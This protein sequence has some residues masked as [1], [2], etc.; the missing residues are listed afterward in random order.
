MDAEGTIASQARAH[1]AAVLLDTEA[2]RKQRDHNNNINTSETLATTSSSAS[3]TGNKVE[4]RDAHGIG[5]P[6]GGHEKTEPSK[7]DSAVKETDLSRQEGD[8]AVH[9]FYAKAAGLR[10]VVFFLFA[11]AVS[12]ATDALSQIWVVWWTEAIAEDPD[13]SNGKWLGV[14]A[15]LGIIGVLANFLA[16]WEIF[17]TVI[18]K[19]GL[20]FHSLLVKTVSQAPMSFFYTVDQGVTV[21]RF[22]QD[23]QLIDMELPG[24]ALGAAMALATVVG[25]AVIIGVTGRYIAI[26]FPF[27]IAVFYIIQKFYL[28]TSRQMR[29]LDIEHTAPLYSHTIEILDGLASIRA[30]SYEEGCLKAMCHSLNES[31]RPAYILACLQQWLLFASDMTVA[32]MAVLLIIIT[33]TLRQEI[34]VGFMGLALSNIVAFGTTVQM[35]LV[36]WVQL[37]ISIGAIARIKKFSSSI[38]SET[39][40]EPTTPGDDWP[41]QGQISF[42]NVS[43]S[44]P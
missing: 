25:Q 33:T 8:A 35:L 32:V 7:E 6:N 4:P 30:F 24:S 34:G 13:E 42:S 22:S 19:T 1:E 28:R 5:H 21:N 29:F 27:I 3:P 23:I 26:A 44:Y 37:E 14:Y 40:D 10:S 43:A 2:P 17:I 36:T 41:L 31:Q 9:K 18:T 20:Y 15:A 38:D 11:L 16:A 12:A 39:L